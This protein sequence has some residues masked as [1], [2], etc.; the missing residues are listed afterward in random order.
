MGATTN[1]EKYGNVIFHHML[2][3]NYKI[4]PVNPR[5]AKTGIDGL[6]CFADLAEL[7]AHLATLN[8]KIDIINI[9]LPAKLG[10]EVAAEAKELELDNL[11]FQ[12]G[13]ESD[14]LEKKCQDLGLNFM[15]IACLMVV[16]R[17]KA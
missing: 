5:A 10:L 6:R 1:K 12:P 14:E 4:F 2:N 16:A 3:K 15:F 13:A 7:K 9:V 17:P 11:W 8:E